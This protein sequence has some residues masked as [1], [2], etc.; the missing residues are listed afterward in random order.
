MREF[1]KRSVVKAATWRL[2]ATVSTMAIVYAF[3]REMALSLGVGIVEVVL[4][5]LLYYFHER[6]WHQIRWGRLPHPLSGLA[7][8][9]ELEAAHLEEIRKRL[10]ELGYL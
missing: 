8:T 1:H 10:G 2:L 3:T 5:M 6:L 4:K 9:R 7:V